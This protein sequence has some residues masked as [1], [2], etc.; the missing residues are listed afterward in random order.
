MRAEAL[1][2][3]EAPQAGKDF[4]NRKQEG[5]GSTV[6]HGHAM[7][8]SPKGSA[9]TRTG[10]E[11]VEM[12]LEKQGAKRLW[13]RLKEDAIK[14]S[15]GQQQT[16]ETGCNAVN[17]GSCG[18]C[19]CDKELFRE[20]KATAGWWL[21]EQRKVKSRW[22]SKVREAEK[23]GSGENSQPLPKFLEYNQDCQ[24]TGRQHREVG[25]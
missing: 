1:G 25:T 20:A 6:A 23:R 22:L 7:W 9:C 15:R 10:L 24:E 11:R 16:Q 2:W 14:A 12:A 3:K 18:V 21:P 8:A 5:S 17:A 4:K 19:V 13:S